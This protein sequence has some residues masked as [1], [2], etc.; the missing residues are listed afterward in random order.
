MT[1]I[2]AIQDEISQAIVKALEMKLGRPVKRAAGAKQAANPEAY[3]A[4]LEGRYYMQQVTSKGAGRALEC[5]ERAIQLDPAYAM[6]YV[7][8]AQL[9][10][11]Q[12]LYRP[13]AREKR[14]PQR[15]P[16][17]PGHCNWIRKPRTPI[18]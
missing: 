11:Y 9:A 8:L 1:D 13:C 16:S 2:F 15:L 3:Q 4:Y 18:W 14:H 6:P 17:W 7:G 10:Y 5:Y 12:S